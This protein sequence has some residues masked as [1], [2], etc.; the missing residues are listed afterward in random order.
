MITTTS[1]N[2]HP[3]MKDYIPADQIGRPVLCLDLWD[4]AHSPRF[5]GDREK[6]IASWWN[7][8]NWSFMSRAYGIVTN[9]PPV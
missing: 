4:H 5:N 1:G 6:Y 9:S 2:D 3:K 7:V 8:V